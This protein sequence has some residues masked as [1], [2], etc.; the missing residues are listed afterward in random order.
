[1]VKPKTQ[2]R[3]SR[4][5]KDGS[6]F[7]FGGSPGPVF[8]AASSPLS[9]L[10]ELPDISVISDANT[11]VIFKNLFKK[12]S[13]TKARALEDLQTSL[14]AILESHSAVEDSVVEAWVSAYRNCPFHNQC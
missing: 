11:V 1:M 8:G 4:A 6:G 12:D 3:S 14:T 2:A 5:A 9:Y 7:A 10:A 13:T